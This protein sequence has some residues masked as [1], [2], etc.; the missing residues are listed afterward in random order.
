MILIAEWGSRL[1]KDGSP[2][3]GTERS[4]FA[5][6]HHGFRDVAAR[7]IGISVR[8]F[9]TSWIAVFAAG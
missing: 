7:S 3:P 1:S 8:I 4:D 2:N 5:R 9:D 6:S